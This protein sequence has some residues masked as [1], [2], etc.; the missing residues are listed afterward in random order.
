M[1]MPEIKPGAPFLLIYQIEAR[2]SGF[3]LERKN[4]TIGRSD[5]AC[6]GG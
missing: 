3:D 1:K 4:N 6:G 2:R 5:T